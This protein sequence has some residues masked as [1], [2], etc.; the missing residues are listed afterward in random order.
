MN[1]KNSR[2]GYSGIFKNGK[3]LFKPWFKP[4]PTQLVVKKKY[5]SNMKPPANEDWNSLRGF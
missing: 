2:L 3:T 5:I 1:Q 4:Q